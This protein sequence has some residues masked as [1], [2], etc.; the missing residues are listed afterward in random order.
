MTAIDARPQTKLA[1]WLD[2]QLPDIGQTFEA[3]Y[4][5]TAV[6]DDGTLDL[7]IRT[8]A[9]EAPVWVVGRATG[10]SE[11]V[12]YEGINATSGTQLTATN[13]KRSSSTAPTVTI[14]HTP[15]VTAG[16]I[17]GA[18]ATIAGEFVPAGSFEKGQE[19][20]P[21]GWI[22]QSNTTYMFRHTNRGGAPKVLSD[23]IRWTEE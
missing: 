2:S 15:N 16:D 6:A 3:A 8:G 11:Y 21:P 22:L 1:K 14:F 20:G 18:S 23:L 12:L 17:S 4:F 13:L 10:N 19:N 5:N 9:N 7:R